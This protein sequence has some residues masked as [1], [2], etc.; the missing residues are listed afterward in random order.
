[1]P[2]A[3]QAQRLKH[4]TTEEVS[5]SLML[6]IQ[7]PICWSAGQRLIS[8]KANAAAQLLGHVQLFV[9]PWTISR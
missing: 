9:T 4:W 1:M 7:L 6:H 8:L 3:L 2:S 5:V